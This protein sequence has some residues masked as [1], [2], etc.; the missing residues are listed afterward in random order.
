MKKIISA[1]LASF[2]LLCLPAMCFAQTANPDY[3]RLSA[4]DLQTLA[5]KG[6]MH[7]VFTQGYNLIFD[8]NQNLQPN[9]NFQ[10]AIALLETAHANGHDTAN[11]ILMLYYEGEFGHTPDFARVET[12]LTTSAERGSAIAQLN[13]ATR[14]L[15]AN[16]PAKS[17]RAMKYLFSASKN[18]ATKEIAYPYL[19]DVLYGVG[20]DKKQNPP[21]A[22]QKSIECTQVLPRNG[23]CHYLLGRDFEDGWG[24]EKN[25]SKSD[26]HLKKAADL[27]DAGAQ[28]TIGMRYLNGT[29][30]EKNE[31]AAFEWV[32]KSASQ[33]Y[34]DGLISFAVMNAIGQ[35]TDINKAAAFEAYEIAAALGSAHAL[36]GLG[37]M[38]CAGEAPKTDRNVC[39][40]ALILAYQGGDDL[41]GDLL[42]RFFDV[43]DQTG[44]DA[45]EKAMTPTMAS[46]MDRYNIQFNPE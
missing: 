20:F 19:I 25:I 29:R 17:D 30:V 13:Y 41:A 33:E 42:T 43:T 14:F 46:V 34:V 12:L 2:S 37:S 3:S 39:A 24:G 6:D 27:G 9:P 15:G 11:S 10:K 4:S 1:L 31:K 44:F 7:A 23:Y 45:L 28:W 18:N 26:F 16:D 21:L 22:R 8:A 32:K 35:G 38:Y 40:A 5:N 36:R